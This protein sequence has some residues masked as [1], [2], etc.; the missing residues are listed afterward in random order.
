MLLQVTGGRNGYG[1]KLA[2][3]FSMKLNPVSLPHTISMLQPPPPTS[4]TPEPHPFM[5]LLQLLVAATG[6]ASSWPASS[7]PL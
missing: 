2:N 1:V 6:T 7:G 4:P 5:H 3:I